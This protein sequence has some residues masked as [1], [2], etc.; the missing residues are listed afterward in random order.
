MSSPKNSAM[1]SAS[2]DPTQVRAD[3]ER[4]RAELAETVQALAAKADVKA[5]AQRSAQQARAR[6]EGKAR[7]FTDQVRG[8]GPA[9]PI[10]VG[11]ALLALVLLLRRAR[12]RGDR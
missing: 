5:R 1:G 4:A 2:T 7:E 11:A 6:A 8:T 3:A 9:V 12:R 10:A